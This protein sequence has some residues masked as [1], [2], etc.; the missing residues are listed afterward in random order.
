M[1]QIISVFGIDWR[2]L[3]I[4]AV[5]FGIV[6]FVLHRFFYKPVL[7]MI[8]E[9]KVKIEQG[10]KDAE[11]AGQKLGR[12]TEDAHS[13][14]L[15]AEREAS[16]TLISGKRAA[17]D[18]AAAISEEAEKKVARVLAET[19]KEADELKRKALDDSR[20]EIARLGILAAEKILRKQS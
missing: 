8:D 5:N 18:K 11:E 20:E 13:I 19:Q 7:K 14:V 2:L 17:E 12:A 6:L 1:E 15:K 9:R 10:V 4:Q 16:E 3:L